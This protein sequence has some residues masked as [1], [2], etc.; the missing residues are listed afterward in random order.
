MKIRIL[1]HLQWNLNSSLQYCC[2]GLKQYFPQGSETT[3][4]TMKK[5]IL[6]T[7]VLLFAELK[8]NL[9]DSSISPF[10]DMKIGVTYSTLTN[11]KAWRPKWK[12]SLTSAKGTGIMPN[13]KT[14]GVLQS[15]FVIFFCIITINWYL[16]I[17]INYN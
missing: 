13:F 15:K 4:P 16:H 14:T 17:K 1:Y 7:S 8:Y 11:R 6:A 2:T 12:T 3:T 10:F 5:D 9:S